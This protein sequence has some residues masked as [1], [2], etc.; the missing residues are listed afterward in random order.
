[1]GRAG[2]D[3]Q[4]FN[5]EGPTLPRPYVFGSMYANFHEAPFYW[6]WLKIGIHCAKDIRNYQCS[7]F[8][9]PTPH[10]FWVVKVPRLFRG[11]VSHMSRPV[12]QVLLIAEKVVLDYV[13]LSNF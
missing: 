2:L 4:T 8:F 5:F 6:K 3:P 1:M 12:F 7:R 10:V 9:L 11:S 13:I